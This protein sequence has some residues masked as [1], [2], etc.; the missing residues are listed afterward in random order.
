MIPSTHPAKKNYQV[1]SDNNN[2]GES[3]MIKK[4]VIH[5][6]TFRRLSQSGQ[7]EIEIIELE[8]KIEYLYPTYYLQCCT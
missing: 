1:D 3:N 2:W 5:I 6:I 4:K 8:I 7:I